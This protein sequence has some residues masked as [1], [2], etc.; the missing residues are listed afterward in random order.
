MLVEDAGNSGI[1]ETT[2]H[3]VPIDLAKVT[4]SLVVYSLHSHAEVQQASFPAASLCCCGV[5][6]LRE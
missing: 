6:M 1:L 3:C 2:K 5:A 4:L